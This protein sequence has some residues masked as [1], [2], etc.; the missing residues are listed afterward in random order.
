MFLLLLFQLFVD[1]SALCCLC[2]CYSSFMLM[3]QPHVV[4]VS[5]VYVFIHKMLILNLCTEDN[6]DDVLAILC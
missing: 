5:D 3:I 2:F 1:D 6:Y 4:V